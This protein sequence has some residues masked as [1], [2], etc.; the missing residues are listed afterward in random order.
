MLEGTT[1]RLAIFCALLLCAGCGASIELERGDVPLESVFDSTSFYLNVN[2]GSRTK[3]DNWD[4]HLNLLWTNDEK[5]EAV[6]AKNLEML[7]SGLK[8]GGFQFVDEISDG[9]VCADLRFKSVRFDPVG[10]WLTDD[11]RIDYIDLASGETLGT[12][13]ADEIWITPTVKMVFEALLNG[14]LELWGVA[15]E[16]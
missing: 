4:G 14:S 2:D 12:V 16:E 1:K 3:P 5:R 13:V 10:G 6:V 11:A 9:T 7:L 8:A 15:S